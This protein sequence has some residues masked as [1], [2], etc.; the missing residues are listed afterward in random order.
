MNNTKSGL[1]T[2]FISNN[3]SLFAVRSNCLVSAIAS[4]LLRTSQLR[5]AQ[6]TMTIKGVVKLDLV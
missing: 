3:P 6:R 2:P 5:R 1:V 4:G